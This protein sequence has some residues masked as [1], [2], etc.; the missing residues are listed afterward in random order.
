MRD[1]TTCRMPTASVRSRT[2]WWPAVARQRGRR[3]SRRHNGSWSESLI[4]SAAFSSIWTWVAFARRGRA[5]WL[6]THVVAGTAHDVAE[7]VH[8]LVG[9]RAVQQVAY[10][11]DVTGEDLGDTGSARLCDV[12]YRGALVMGTDFAGDQPCVFQ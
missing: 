4:M 10:D 2:V 1:I 11:L 12:D 7:G 6:V 3:K 9:K 5:G 8:V